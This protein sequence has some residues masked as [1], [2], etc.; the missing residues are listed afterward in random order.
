MRVVV[1]VLGLLLAA[2]VRD[3]SVS[4]AQAA[5][6]AEVAAVLLTQGPEEEIPRE[7]WSAELRALNA[8][9]VRV[10]EEGVYVVTDSC[11]VEEAGL[12]VPRHPEKFVAVGGDP[13]Y[14][15]IHGAVFSYRVRG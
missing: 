4:H 5:V 8:K 13:E 9:S 10:D 2:W 14:R 12:F 7:A 6:V 15:R 11:F 1:C 3:P